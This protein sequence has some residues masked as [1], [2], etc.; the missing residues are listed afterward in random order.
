ML[1]RLQDLTTEAG[2]VQFENR[3]RCQD[4]SY[5]WLLWNV[6]ACQDEQLIYAVARDNTECRRAEAA[7]RESE[8]RFRLLVEGVKDYAIIMLNPAGRI[9]SWNTG[10]ERIQQY[11][12]SEILG[13]HISCFYTR[14]RY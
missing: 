1:E 9:V 8:E 14:E 2:T 7:Q 6:T 11:Q 12:A 3:Y 5:K 10:A 4:G 13:K